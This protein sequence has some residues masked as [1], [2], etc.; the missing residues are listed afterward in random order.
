[1]HALNRAISA[2]F[3]EA[4]SFQLLLLVIALGLL[5]RHL[6]RGARTL[7]DQR[8]V[9]LSLLGGVLALLV[10]GAAERTM[11]V[12]WLLGLPPGWVGN[13]ALGWSKAALALGAAWLSI[14]EAAYLAAKKKVRVCWSKGI[15][16]IRK[17]TPVSGGKNIAA[18]ACAR[19]ARCTWCWCWLWA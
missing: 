18:R 17:R 5:V 11:P 15:S 16:P 7:S 9:R 10:I 8:F 6:V 3:T 19:F 1:M 2:W 14:R 13:K 12:A 4:W